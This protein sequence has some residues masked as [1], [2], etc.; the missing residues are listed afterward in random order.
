MFRNLKI[1]IRLA[2]AFGVVLLLLA[3]VSWEG[4]HSMGI[5]DTA[6]M[7]IVK[8][9]YARGVVLEHANENLNE[10]YQSLSVIMSSRDKGEQLKK[11]KDLETS[12]KNFNDA[13]DIY[14]KTQDHQEGLDMLAK[15]K[16]VLSESI[17]PMDEVIKLSLANKPEDARLLYLNKVEP[18]QHEV[19]NVF[20]PMVVFEEQRIDFRY[21]QTVDEYRSSIKMMLLVGGIAI[22]LVVI[23]SFFLTRGITKPLEAALKVANKVSDGDLTA[24]IAVRSKDEVGQ[25]GD[26]INRMVAGLKEMVGTVN[27]SAAQV[28]AAADQVNAS[29]HQIQKGAQTQASAADETS[30][31]MEEMAASIQ[32]VAQNAGDLAS[33]VDE[34]SASINQMVAS[35]EQVARNSG[36]MASSVSET[37]ATVEQMAASIDQVAN[38]TENLSA[39][40]QETSATIDQMMASIEQVARNSDM[41]SGTVAETSSTVEEMAASIKQVAGNVAEAGRISQKAAEDAVAGGEAVELTIEGINRIADTMK[42]TSEVIGSL[43]RRSEEIG[44][45]IG[46]IEDIADQTNLLALNAAIEAARAGDAGRGFAVVADEVRKLAERSVV[47]TKEI[48]E[49]IEQVQLETSKAV[50]TAEVGAAETLE[51]KKLADKAGASL[52]RILDSVGATNQIMAEINDAAAEQSSAANMVLKSVENMNQV[53]DQVITAVKEQAMGSNQIRKAVET[54]NRT[55]QQVA[56]AMKEQAMG[57]KQIR[58]AV[59]DMNRVTNEVNIAAKEQAQGTVQIMK[60]VENMNSMTQQVANATSEQKRGGELVVKAVENISDIARENLAAVKQMTAASENITFQAESLQRAISMFKVSDLSSVQACWDILNC[61][62][63]NRMKCPAYKSPEKRCWLIEGTWC[64]GVLQGD[65]RSKLANCMHC[66]AFKVMQGVSSLPAA[67]VRSIG[68]DRS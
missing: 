36:A 44:K 62:M 18:Q 65:A 21:K 29:S 30:S 32:M 13:M 25:L 56:G 43:G 37:S 31:S 35:I 47:A 33:N 66:N 38:D 19:R 61:D 46:V 23:M 41:L 50:K 51:G 9:N 24:S 26:A 64:K 14:E 15:F 6:A 45:I 57:G 27:Q 63:A 49:V 2:M 39:S 59:E 3:L 60:A 58:V 12:R 42:V 28:A 40:V 34:T 55:T 20:D 10:M 52:K 67:N 48:G 8:K 16:A 68:S 7:H 1:G 11:V 5:M 17:K 53:T 54:M 4:L 22:V